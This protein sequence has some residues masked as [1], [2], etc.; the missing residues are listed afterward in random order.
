MRKDKKKLVHIPMWIMDKLEK[1]KT[2]TTKSINLLIVE[3]LI[4]KLKK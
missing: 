4:E 2:K 1:E 3:A